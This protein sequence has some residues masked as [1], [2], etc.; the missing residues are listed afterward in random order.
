MHI[1]DMPIRD[2]LVV[3]KGEVYYL[4]DST[5]KDIWKG[6]GIGFDGYISSPGSFLCVRSLCPCEKPLNRAV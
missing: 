6:P 4:F 3:R 5:D 1:S 2:P